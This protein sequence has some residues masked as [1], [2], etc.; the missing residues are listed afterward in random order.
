M[1]GLILLSNTTV[2]KDKLVIKKE[3]LEEL[4]VSMVDLEEGSELLRQILSRS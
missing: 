1:T 3:T 4:F 2:Y